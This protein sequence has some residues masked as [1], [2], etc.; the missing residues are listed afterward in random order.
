MLAFYDNVEDHRGADVVLVGWPLSVGLGRILIML[1]L[2][3]CR[4]RGVTLLTAIGE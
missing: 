2:I 3:F 1:L 4:C